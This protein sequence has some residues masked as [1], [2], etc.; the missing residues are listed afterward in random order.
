MSGGAMRI[1]ARLMLA[2][3]ALAAGGGA[4]AGDNVTAPSTSVI[5]SGV[6]QGAT[7]VVAVNEAAGLNNGQSNQAVIVQG[8]AVGL[9][10]A[11]AQQGAVTKAA[12]GAAS[13]TIES[14]AFSAA[15]GLV[16]V[17]QASG[18]GNLQHNIAAFVSG[19]VSG[20]EI[21]PDTALSGAIS[22]GGL[23]GNHM[24]SDRYRMAS[25]APDAFMNTSGIVQVNQ[26]AGVG[27]VT[28]NVFVLRP[29]AGTS[30]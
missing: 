18:S 16:Q 9:G 7:G 14:A 25:I 23:A 5:G 15:S 3:A 10:V 28:A 4:W 2:A 17:N 21:V 19:G 29:P 24:I 20:V 11:G 1:G 22:K 13:S 12:H 6:A 26:S 8:N 30:F 27:N